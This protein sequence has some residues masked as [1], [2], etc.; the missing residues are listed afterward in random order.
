M[1]EMQPGKEG[2][3]ESLW[4]PSK[5]RDANQEK[6][7]DITNIRGSTLS[8]S[9]DAEQ[10]STNVSKQLIESG[11]GSRYQPA[12]EKDSDRICTKKRKIISQVFTKIGSL[13]AEPT[14][15]SN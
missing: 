14:S 10:V 12:P 2:S 13:D 4:T 7:S 8:E 9:L 5:S 15:A 3:R 11:S 6:K 1:K